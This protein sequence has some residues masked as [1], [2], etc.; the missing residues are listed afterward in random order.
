MGDLFSHPSEGKGAAFDQS[1]WIRAKKGARQVVTGELKVSENG[2]Y[3]V[4]VTLEGGGVLFGQRRNL[5]NPDAPA[6]ESTF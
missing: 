2:V 3:R 1:G 5:V 4:R 6:G